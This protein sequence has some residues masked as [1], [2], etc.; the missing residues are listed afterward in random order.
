MVLAFPSIIIWGFGI[1][2][3]AWIVFA[4]N[5]EIDN[6]EVREKYGFLCNGYKKEYYFWESINMYRKISIT[7]ISIFLKNS[8]SNNSGTCC[9]LSFDYFSYTKFKTYVIFVCIS[10]RYGVNFND[11]MNDYNILK[12][13][14]LLPKTIPPH[15]PG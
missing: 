15:P 3:F 5:K 4:R 2:L 12:S 7:F 11:N 6:I 1:P 10:K 13:F 14:L 9:F 8:R